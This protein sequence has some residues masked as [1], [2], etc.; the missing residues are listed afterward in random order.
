MNKYCKHEVHR[1]YQIFLERTFDQSDVALFVVLTR[2]YSEK[3]SVLRELGDFLAHL[4]G[5][6]R[7]V[8]L[9]RVEKAA[10]GIDD[11]FANMESVGAPIF[12]GI[13]NEEEIIQDLSNIFQ[14]AGIKGVNIEKNGNDIRDFIFCVIFLLS[15]FKLKFRNMLYD[16]YVEYSHGVT[17]FTS[18]EGRFN[19]HFHANLPILS[20]CNVWIECPPSGICQTKH[21]LNNHVVRRFDQGHLGALDYLLDLKV[22]SHDAD[23]FRKGELWPLPDLDRVLESLG[24]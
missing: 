19:P 17:L 10:E 4:K 14:R 2:D 18:V 15:S 11:Y 21:V 3:G 13:G 7:G 9:S 12:E 5:K 22:S 1:F 16:F 23:K 8:T 6:D 20:L 24:H